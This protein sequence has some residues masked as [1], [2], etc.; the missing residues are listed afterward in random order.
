[1]KNTLSKL[2]NTNSHPKE[3]SIKSSN[4]NKKRTNKIDMFKSPKTFNPSLLDLA[5]LLSQFPTFKAMKK[6]I[7]YPPWQS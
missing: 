4:N 2:D 7:R 6:S 5:T 3:F 1:M